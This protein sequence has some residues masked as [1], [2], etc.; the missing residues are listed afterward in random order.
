MVKIKVF[1]D[2]VL[3][4]GCIQ[5]KVQEKREVKT[6]WKECNTSWPLKCLEINFVYTGFKF[7]LQWINVL[8]LKD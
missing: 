2:H 6:D 7:R 1:I 3:V 5:N 4:L 8:V